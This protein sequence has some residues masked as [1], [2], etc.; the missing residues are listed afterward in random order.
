MPAVFD[1][2]FPFQ[3]LSQL[4][5]GT[6]MIISASVVIHRI[7]N[8]S[9]NPLAYTLMSLSLTVGVS[10][11]GL[12]LTDAFRKEVTLPDR[13][14]HFESEYVHETCNYLY[15]ISTALQGWVFAMRYLQSA[16]ESSLT[17][18][19]LTTECIKYTGWGFGIGYATVIT[20]FIVW[21]MVSFPGYLD[22]NGSL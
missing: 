17:K 1:P 8:K 15:Y 13:V 2:Y 3:D 6:V 12:A 21:V 22:A 11:I 19:C 4:V 20:V 7:H 18:T 9:K 14:H 5:G 16:T 10:N